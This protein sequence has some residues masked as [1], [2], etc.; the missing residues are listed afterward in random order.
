M[1]HHIS[2]YKQ[3]EVANPQH[4]LTCQNLIA[5]ACTCLM[6]GDQGRTVEGNKGKRGNIREEERGRAGEKG[7]VEKM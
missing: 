4:R 7:K 1:G 6:L 3:Q 2:A 5:H